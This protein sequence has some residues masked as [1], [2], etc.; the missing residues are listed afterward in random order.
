DDEGGIRPIEHRPAHRRIAFQRFA[1]AVR[2][3]LHETPHLVQPTAERMTTKEE[4]ARS[5]TAQ[6]TAESR[7]SDSP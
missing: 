1:V 7:S 6:L 4:S 5:S 2:S 3:P